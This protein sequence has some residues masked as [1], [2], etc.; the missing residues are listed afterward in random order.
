MAQRTTN[1]ED[2]K[3]WT[4][5]GSLWALAIPRKNLG[6][7]D[8]SKR[9]AEDAMAAFAR[10]D[11]PAVLFATYVIASKVTSANF[12]RPANSFEQ[13]ELRYALTR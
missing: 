7:S 6:K 13:F 3:K 5:I 9:A 2:K 4:N 8:A 10:P 11:V 12:S 1:E